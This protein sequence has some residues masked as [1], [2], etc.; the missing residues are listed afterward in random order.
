MKRMFAF[1]HGLHEALI[2]L[3]LN[4]RNP[5]PLPD[6]K[7]EP[8]PAGPRHPADK[9]YAEAQAVLLSML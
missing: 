2:E 1:L 6:V 5:L 9:A 7:F 3:Y 8:P 4:G